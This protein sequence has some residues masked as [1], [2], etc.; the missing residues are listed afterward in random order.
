[1]KWK[2]PARE[3]RG[4]GTK[5]E[6]IWANGKITQARTIHEEKQRLKTILQP[7]EKQD[8]ILNFIKLRYNQPFY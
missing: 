4:S 6:E 2:I 3:T 8:I 1:M 7:R 5:C